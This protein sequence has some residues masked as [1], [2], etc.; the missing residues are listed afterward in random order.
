MVVQFSPRIQPKRQKKKFI[1]QKSRQDI[2]V[3]TTVYIIFVK[4]N[5]KKDSVTG[6]ISKA[7]VQNTQ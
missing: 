2:V 7:Q 1:R 4:K 3:I 6:G 5:C